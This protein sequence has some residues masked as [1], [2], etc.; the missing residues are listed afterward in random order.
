MATRPSRWRVLAIVPETQAGDGCT[1]ELRQE[2]DSLAAASAEVF[3]SAQPDLAVTV[4]DQLC[5]MPR[6]VPLCLMEVCSSQ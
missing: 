4:Y 6:R 3:T 2:P 1:S 5:L